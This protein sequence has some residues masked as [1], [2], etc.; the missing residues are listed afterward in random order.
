[1]AVSSGV[2][3]LLAALLALLAKRLNAGGFNDDGY[4]TF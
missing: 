2:F 1:M 3:H 4:A